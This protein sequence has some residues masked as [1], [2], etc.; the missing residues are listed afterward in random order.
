MVSMVAKMRRFE[1]GSVSE[2]TLRGQD[3]LPEFTDQLKRFEPTHKLVA[4]AY[5]LMAEW[6]SEDPEEDDQ[7]DELVNEIQDALQAYCPPFVSFGAHPGDGAD[8]GFWPEMESL[9]EARRYSNKR[10]GDYEYLQDDNVWCQ[11]SDHG[12][13]TILADDNGQPGEE[14]WSVV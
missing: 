14:I 1:L 3:L 8:F 12:N 10:D 4:E 11:V 7:I 13:V 9:E 5:T 2:G 6:G